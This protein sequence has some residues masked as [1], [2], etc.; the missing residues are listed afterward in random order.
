MRA[1]HWQ[2]ASDFGAWASEYG[3]HRL[4]GELRAPRRAVWVLVHQAACRHTDSTEI[5]HS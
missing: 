4:A 1:T 5:T 2:A 3:V